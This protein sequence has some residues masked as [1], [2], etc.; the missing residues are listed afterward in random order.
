LLALPVLLGLTPGAI[1]ALGQELRHQQIRI[2]VGYSPGGGFDA[3]SRVLARHFGHGIPGNPSVR[4][5]NM[6]G[7]GSL[8]A[9]NYLYRL[10]KPD[11]HTVGHFSGGL[12]LGQAFAQPG[13]EFDARQFEYVG[14]PAREHIVCAF[15][16]A[17][18]ITSLA[19]WKTAST[20]VKMGGVAPGSTTPDNA[21]RIV[22]AALGLPVQLITGYKGTADI[23]LAVDAGELAGACFNWVS[24][25]AT[26]GEALR[27]GHVAVVLQL[28]PRPHPDLP[29]VPLAAELVRTEDAHRLVEIG[30][31]AS[32]A[33]VR[34]YALPPGTPKARVQILR[35]AFLDTL[36][37][38][39]FLADA[40]RAR[41][42]VDPVPGEEIE[43]QVHELFHLDAATLAKLR[44]ILLD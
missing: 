17:S 39:A 27:S 12:L 7:A 1:R 18:G 44:S 22:R 26:W 23:R 32:N 13:V 8:I 40:E 3:Y 28:A 20:P 6:P 31:H 38:P 25:R 36:R 34:V 29:R 11:G 35:Q 15:S 10:A 19:K 33:T 42:E 43:R 30:I 24:M 21:T 5:E 2:L 37:D 9:A 14:A 16:R 4:V 41:L